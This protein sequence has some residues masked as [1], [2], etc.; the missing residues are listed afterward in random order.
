MPPLFALQDRGRLARLAMELVV[1]L[2]ILGVT[3]LL[4]VMGAT[5]PRTLRCNIYPRM[6]EF[7][8]RSVSIPFRRL[9]VDVRREFMQRHSLVRH[10]TL[11]SYF[12][13]ALQE[14]SVGI[15]ACFPVS[16]ALACEG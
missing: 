1:R 15:V 3:W 2:G 8:R 14:D 7:A 9:F 10:S 4:H 13:D 6:K 16:R 11:G 12:R 5:L